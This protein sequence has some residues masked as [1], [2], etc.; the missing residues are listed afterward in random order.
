MT[1][2]PFRHD[3]P[4][5]VIWNLLIL[6]AVLV[7]SFLTTYR[8]LYKE[9]S[10]DWLYYALN[11]LLLLDIG[12]NFF[13]RV[14]EG[15]RRYDTLPAIARFY[16]RSWLAV[17]ILS[18]F[19]FELIVVAAFGGVPKDPAW[20]TVYLTLQ[21]LT[22]IKL[23][24]AVRI[25]KELQMALG[26]SDG[27][28]RLVNFGYWLLQVIHLMAM[29][30]ILIG[31]G[32]SGRD[33]FD[34]YLRAVYWVTTTIATIGYG[35]YFPNHDSNLQIM[36]TIVV[37]LFGVSMYT[38]VI[39]NVSSLI[40]NL[41]LAKAAYQQKVSEVNSWLKANAIPAALQERIRD[42]YSYLHAEKKSLQDRWVVEELPPSLGLEILLHQNRNL[43]ERVDFF[44]GADEVFVREILLSLKSKVFVPG[45]EVLREGE[46]GEAMYFLTDGEMQV[47]V[48][49]RPVAKLGPGSVFGEAALVTD[50]RRN[51]SVVALDYGNGYQLD[52]ADFLQLC[53]LH[54]DFDQHVQAI[55]QSRQ[56][57][58]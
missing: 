25:F 49:G 58:D 3:G 22:L 53:R 33:Q 14:K 5:K 39:A 2:Q 57:R 56:R 48:G 34:Q 24:K 41:D 7:I 29:G 51:A 6:L 54:P 35:D 47:L 44:K 42:Y 46:A 8:L 11:T 13:T 19:P 20:F 1:V 4:F 36:Y 55:V 50:E 17:D 52:K 16:T 26:F 9:F 10:A 21:C 18:F 32:E 38:F 31:A 37:Q 27:L 23:L 12:V 30:W 28:R 40:S 15:H 45:E 43:L